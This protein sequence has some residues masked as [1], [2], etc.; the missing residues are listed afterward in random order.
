MTTRPHSTAFVVSLLGVLVL[1][2]PADA[3]RG[4]GSRGGSSQ[5]GGS[6]GGSR[7]GGGGSSHSSPPRSS[8]SPARSSPSP[9][10]RSSPTPT[11]RSQPAPTPRS[12]P[13][14]V[15]STPRHTTS[16]PVTQPP[17]RATPETSSRGRSERSGSSA[18]RASDSP[19]YVQPAAYARV[20]DS[21]PSSARDTTARRA[22]YA[23]R[24]AAGGRDASGAREGAVQPDAANFID[25]SGAA[26]RRGDVIPRLSGSN[27]SPARRGPGADRVAISE[28]RSLV[29]G[30]ASRNVP[31]SSS[32]VP[33]ISSREL[34]REKL[35][36]RYGKRIDASDHSAR[37]DAAQANA[38][39]AGKPDLSRGR[40]ATKDTSKLGRTNPD[41][42]KVVSEGRSAGTSGNGSRGGPL[43]KPDAAKDHAERIKYAR[44]E[45]LQ[46]KDP[47]TARQVRDAG[48]A[49]ARVNSVTSGRAASVGLGYGSN[50]YDDWFQ[51]P[52]YGCDDG[53]YGDG[54]YDGWYWGCNTGY[55]P[56]YGWCNGWG[57]SFYWGFSSLSWWW[58]NQCAYYP[59]YSSGW[60]SGPY[61]YTSVIY[62][63]YDPPVEQVVVYVDS[64][65]PTDSQGE[66]AIQVANAPVGADPSAVSGGAVAKSPPAV[67]AVMKAAAIEY[68]DKGDAAFREGRYSDAAHHY[69]RS[70]EYEPENPINY[71]VLA[72]ALFATGDYH[73]AAFALGKAVECDAN[74]FDKLVDKHAFYADP[75]EFDRQIV[76]AEEY[77]ND[78]FLDDDARLVLAA[79]YLYA[80][81]MA[82]ALDLLSSSFSAPV[83]E[84]KAGAAL[85][86]RAK[87]AVDERKSGKN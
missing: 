42:S 40:A 22:D 14:R 48:A 81:R 66:G 44:L 6:S 49:L 25:L 33:S 74:I 64:D 72:D 63:D 83:R 2:T 13:S 11:P 4:G 34:T 5:G 1:A 59:Y 82:Q 87:K 84:S 17:V 15:D 85:L 35:L 70:I 30:I 54:Y 68:R 77:L 39:G 43:G 8:P 36:E 65:P 73:Y 20:Y 55:Y 31:A 71:L 62:E 61:A 80:N 86:D 7:G 79:N 75:A 47:G 3:Q 19:R 41:A 53:G 27:S 50:C 52:Y 56:A 26:P 51:D 16:P 9:S 29:G 67:Q 24:E 32:D 12:A 21:S 58:W 18:G 37:G 38:P 23:G 46:Q 78:H 57:Y 60:Y 45:A 28:G 10:A 69:A 76:F